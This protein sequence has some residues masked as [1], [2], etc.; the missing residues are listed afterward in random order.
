MKPKTKDI[1][2]KIYEVVRLIPFGK[3]TTYGAIANFMGTKSS[4]RVVGY[5][6]NAAH[7]QLHFVSAHRVVNRLGMLTGKHHFENPTQMQELL[8]M[9]GIVINNDCIQNFE[10]HFWD[11]ALFVKT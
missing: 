1:F 8:E 9:E 7:Q 10:A 2:L 11:P 3:V 6:M 4:A 5:A